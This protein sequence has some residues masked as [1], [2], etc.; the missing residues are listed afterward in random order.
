DR[1]RGKWVEQPADFPLDA[2]GFQAIPARLKE[3]LLQG[4]PG[5]F[6]KACPKPCLTLGWAAFFDAHG[7]AFPVAANRGRVENVPVQDELMLR[8]FRAGVQLTAGI[9]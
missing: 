3:T 4:R 7:G 1:R 2:G 5:C 8:S 9:I 6:G